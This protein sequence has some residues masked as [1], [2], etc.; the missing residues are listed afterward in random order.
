MFSES[1]AQQ[2]LDVMEKHR[3]QHESVY[4]LLVHRPTVQRTDDF[5]PEELLIT[6]DMEAN[7]KALRERTDQDF[8]PLMFVALDD[9]HKSFCFGALGQFVDKPQLQGW[10]NYL[11]QETQK[12]HVQN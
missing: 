9:G 3:M 10:L 4:L 11:A 8:E 2:L 12:K 6:A 1:D 5:V 7:R